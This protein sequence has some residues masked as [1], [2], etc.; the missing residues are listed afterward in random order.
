[1]VACVWFAEMESFLRSYVDKFKYKNISTLEWKNYFLQYF[2]KK[3]R[4]GI[5][6]LLNREFVC[7]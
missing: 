1:M 5:P 7:V 2:Q 4:S 6:C 3:V